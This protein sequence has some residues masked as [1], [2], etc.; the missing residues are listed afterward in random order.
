MTLTQH[1]WK[2]VLW[3]CGVSGDLVWSPRHRSPAVSNSGLTLPGATFASTCIVVTFRIWSACRSVHLT[4]LVGIKEPTHT[5]DRYS[6]SPNITTQ[7]LET[8]QILH[9][10]LLNQKSR[11]ESPW[12]DICLKSTLTTVNFIV[13]CVTVSSSATGGEL[14]WHY[15]RRW[16][17][18]SK[19]LSE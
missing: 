13:A 7:H 19:N 11:C 1:Q 6:N 16:L 3:G 5:F 8:V 10:H 15:V 9:R 14:V 12:H 18:I 17:G 4:T 2:R